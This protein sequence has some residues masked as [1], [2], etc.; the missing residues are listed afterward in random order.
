[1][2]KKF[3][4]NFLLPIIAAIMLT[5][6]F[7]SITKNRN[8]PAREI[9]INPPT[10][11][12]KHK[13]AGVGIVEPETKIINIGT[14][15]TG[16]LKKLYVEEGQSI[17]KNE[18]LFRID[19]RDTIAKLTQA[20]ARVNI[21]LVNYKDLEHSLRLFESVKD[22]RAISVNEISRKR[23]AAAKARAELGE[24]TA[25][26]EVAKITLDRLTVRSPIDGHVL[27]INAK[28]GEFID[29]NHATLP[30]IVIGDLDK[31]HVRVAIDETDIHRLDEDASA[32]GVLR[33]H[34]NLKISL[35][36]V[37]Y[38][39]YVIPKKNLSNDVTEKIDTRVLE[40]I[41]QFDNSRIGAIPGQQMDVFIQEPKE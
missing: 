27:K 18:P 39:P 24:A 10:S 22:K 7:I 3:L 12:F 30:P 14:H 1:M 8:E 2:I 13:V 32:T 15:L 36:F 28:V 35:Y 37:K 25:N 4:I 19:D 5:F 9:L 26:L 16:I 34:D 29:Q 38:E 17:A 33:G 40:L 23:F 6:T 41:Y 20:K 21:A 11:T 31:M